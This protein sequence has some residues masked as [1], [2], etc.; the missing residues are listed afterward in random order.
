[1]I[2]ALAAEK[3]VQ[4]MRKHFWVNGVGLALQS[5]P[6]RIGERARNRVRGVVHEFGTRA[7]V[8]DKRGH[9]D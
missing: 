7:A 3:G 5:A 2:L 9:A 8:D 4:Y 1:M 6:L